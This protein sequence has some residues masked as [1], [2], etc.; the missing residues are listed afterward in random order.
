MNNTKPLDRLR[1][2]R[3][4]AG[5]VSIF[6]AVAL[7]FIAL[8]IYVGA[9]L[10]TNYNDAKITMEKAMTSAVTDYLVSHELKD[11]EGI[12]DTGEVQSRAERYLS[13][14]GWSQEGTVFT[15]S[16]NENPVYTVSDIEFSG[17]REYIIIKGQIS[18]GM[19]FRFMGDLTFDA[20]VEARSSISFIDRS[21]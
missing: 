1:S 7:M 2:R 21:E 17:Q 18:M 15:L 19:P 9:M 12:L 10:Y 11:A 5:Y 8:G 6:F 20:P 4:M 14:M 13:N 3:G 16:K